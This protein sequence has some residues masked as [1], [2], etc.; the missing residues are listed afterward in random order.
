MNILITGGAG[1][2]GSHTTKIL[3]RAGHT[4]VVYDDLSRG[5]KSA[6]LWSPLVEANLSDTNALT[7]AILE[8]KIEA[9]LHFAAYAYVGESM[10]SPGLYFA[11][12][13]INSIRMIETARA[14]GVRYIVFSSTCATY[15]D[16][17]RLPIDETHPQA[18][19]NPYGESKLLFEKVLRWY[20]EI[21]GIKWIALR[22]FN[23][24]GA[25]PDVEIG[26]SHNPETHLIPL[27]IQAAMKPDRPVSVF[28]TDYETPDGTAIRDYIHVNDLGDAHVQ[29]LDYLV[30]GGTSGAFNLGT[31]TGHSVQ[32]VIDTVYERTGLRPAVKYDHR[33]S[34]DP[35][36]LVAD[37]TRATQLLGWQ[38]KLSTL[39][40]IIETA[41]Q[42]FSK[43]GFPAQTQ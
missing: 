38:P 10:G 37:N 27:I 30:N 43:T 33:R 19:V 35:A 6:V 22:Y 17:V 8:Y 21:Y 20:G 12:N 9:I 25:D 32:S 34:G 29:A 1:Y 11:N 39:P 41:Y 24:A 26:E 31:G 7:N 13:S 3:A 16:P 15:G 23:A 28:G 36:K 2:I 40:S 18:P 5:N 4:T 14:A 42:W